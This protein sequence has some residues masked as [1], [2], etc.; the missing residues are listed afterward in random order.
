MSSVGGCTPVDPALVAAIRI[1]PSAYYVNIH[2]AAFPG[3][4]IRGQL[5]S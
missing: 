2:N 1:H 4:A 5:H 3:G